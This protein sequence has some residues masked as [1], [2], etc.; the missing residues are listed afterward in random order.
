M[1]LALQR[2]IKRYEQY[3][4][5]RARAWGFGLFM[6]PIGLLNTLIG[7]NAIAESGLPLALVDIGFVLGGMILLLLGVQCIRG[8]LRIGQILKQPNLLDELQSGKD[9][10]RGVQWS[11][12]SPFNI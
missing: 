1:S 10:M 4:L 3:Q 2:A 5:S 7:I 6:T 9:P 8:A 11:V 12:F